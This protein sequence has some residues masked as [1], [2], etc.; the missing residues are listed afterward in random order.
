MPGL[1]NG[2]L[3]RSLHA[4]TTKLTHVY[5]IVPPHITRSKRTPRLAL[6]NEANEEDED[7]GMQGPDNK[8]RMYVHISFAHNFFLTSF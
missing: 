4:T 2:T 1:A 8:D 3:D 6:A 5:H 7:R